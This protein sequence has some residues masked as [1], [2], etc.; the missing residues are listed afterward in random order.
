MI[1]LLLVSFL[2]VAFLICSLFASIDIIQE[3]PFA[4]ASFREALRI[5][6]KALVSKHKHPLVILLLNKICFV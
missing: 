6:R 1:G 3:Y 5:R 2:A 4:L